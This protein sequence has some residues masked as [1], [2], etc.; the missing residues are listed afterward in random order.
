MNEAI[1]SKPPAHGRM[2]NWLGPQMVQRLLN[3]AQSRRNSFRL[4][5]VSRGDDATIDLTVRRSYKFKGLEELRDELQARARAALPEMFRQLGTGRFEPSKFELEMVAHGDGAFFTEHRDRIRAQTESR[6]ISAVYYFHRLPKP[7]SGGV[8]RIYPL[9]GREKSNT[10]VEIEPVNDTLV[11]FPSWFPHEV[12]SVN[13]PSGK[14]EDS[15]FA[16]NCWI[17]S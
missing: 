16:I 12:L 17:H 2:T 13:C 9:A 5:G 15:R 8:L 11:F 4:S 1:F 10:F 14:F 7:F 6:L 3:F